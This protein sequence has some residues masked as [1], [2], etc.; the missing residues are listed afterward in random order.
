MSAEKLDVRRAKLPP[1]SAALFEA[2]VR[3]GWEANQ[4][5]ESLVNDAGDIV[6]GQQWEDQAEECK[7]TLRDEARAMYAVVAKAGGARVETITGGADE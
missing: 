6:R 1:P 7:A 4:A 3:A 2:M 5:S